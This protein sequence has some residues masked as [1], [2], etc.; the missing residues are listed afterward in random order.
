MTYK[1]FN[2]FCR[3][4]PATTYVVQW[5]GSHVWKVGGKVFAIGGW[6]EHAPSF[7][8]KVSDIA[9]EMLK[10]QAGLRRARAAWAV[11]ARCPSRAAPAGGR[12][13]AHQPLGAEGIHGLAAER[14][15]DRGRERR[16]LRDRWRRRRSGVPAHDPQ[17]RGG[18]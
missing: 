6:Q 16:P 12:D 8:F 2:K 4:L 15:C 3:S 1:E 9:Y 17:Q 7:T 10:E 18:L 11:S 5:G 14:T 13:R